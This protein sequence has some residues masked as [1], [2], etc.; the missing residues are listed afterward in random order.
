MSKEPEQERDHRFR[1]RLSAAVVLGWLVFCGPWLL[2]QRTLIQRDVFAVH[3]PLA[4]QGAAELK[5]GRIPA[6]DTSWGL[7]RPFRSNPNAMAYYPSKLFYLVL[8]FWSAFH[9]HFALHWLLAGLAMAL[10]A[11]RLGQG[12][13]GALTAALAY[14]GGGF[15]ITGLSFYNILAVAAWLPVAAAGAASAGVAW[16]W[17]GLA[18]ALV[19]LAGEPVSAALG[20]VVVAWAAIEVHG[21]RRGVG[22]ALGVGLFGLVLSAPQWVGFLRLL[23]FTSRG[24]MGMEASQVGAF[25]LA[26]GRLLELLVPFPSGVPGRFDAWG[27]WLGQGAPEPPFVL[28]FFVGFLALPLA[29]AAL[30]GG[31]SADEK[32]EDAPAPPIGGLRLGKLRIHGPL[33]WALLAFV[34]LFVAWVGGPAGAL[35]QSLSAGLFRFPEKFLLLTAIGL[36]LVMG[37]GAERLTRDGA[38][39]PSLLG[40]LGLGV[41]IA[42]V[43]MLALAGVGLGSSLLGSSWL[44][45]AMPSPSTP[46]SAPGT[47]L[48]LVGLSLLACGGSWVW[49]SR[50]LGSGSAR[51]ILLVQALGILPLLALAP[52]DSAAPYQQ[53]SPLVD[54]LGERRAVWNPGLPMLALR[55]ALIPRYRVRDVAERQR[56]QALDLSPAPGVLHGLEYPTG[57]DIDGLSSPLSSLVLRRLGELEPQGQYRW[58]RV[59]G[60]EALLLPPEMTWPL[61]ELTR[62]DRPLGGPMTLYAVENPAPRAWWPES[63]ESAAGVAEALSRVANAPD[64]VAQPI[65]VG[66]LPEHGRGRVLDIPSWNGERMELEV[67]G[68]GGLLAIRRSFSPLYRAFAGDQELRTRPINVCL[69]GVEV[70]PGR[71]IVQIGMP[72]AGE[73]AAGALAG[74]AALLGLLVWLRGR[75]G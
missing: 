4:A 53:P 44:D 63:F 19:L 46:D 13:N 54:E 26:P 73:R 33:G 1:R 17:G 10:L 29:W 45:G 37:R 11:R 42:G 56:A 70:P 61:P 67:E 20:S 41:G 30:R 36:A 35:L 31:A 25:S 16:V 15:V 59:L 64:A 57:G 48:L 40:R 58:L 43:G 74:I 8:P 49:V 55:P 5:E 14:A 51:A 27:R 47:W 39:F 3:L 12:P 71:H 68:E 9:L 23:P 66:A 24:A 72:T 6:V 60:V 52:T 2:G 32:A 18:W 22:R 65:L 21:L 7:G 62:V 38:S 50:D 28:S 75:R 34:G 69:L